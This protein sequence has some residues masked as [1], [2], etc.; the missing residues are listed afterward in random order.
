[1][2]AALPTEAP[3]ITLIINALGLHGDHI[4]DAFYVCDTVLTF[5]VHIKGEGSQP[6][7]SCENRIKIKPE[8]CQWCNYQTISTLIYKCA[9][10]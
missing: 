5:C 8:T 1:M 9:E 3:S 2:L 7:Q 10:L 6:W 4:H